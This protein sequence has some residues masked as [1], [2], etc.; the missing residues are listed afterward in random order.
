MPVQKLQHFFDFLA[1]YKYVNIEH[2]KMDRYTVD[3]FIISL[4]VI[5]M[6]CKQERGKLQAQFINNKHG[7][8]HDPLTNCTTE[9]HLATV[10]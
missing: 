9:Q 6:Q 5:Y 3:D 2:N 8:I 1:A 10:I 4:F 7:D